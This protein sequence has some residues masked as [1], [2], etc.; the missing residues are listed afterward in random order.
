MDINTTTY[1]KT[2]IISNVYKKRLAKTFKFA[3]N[4]TLVA[5]AYLEL[6]HDKAAI[7][8]AANV[9]QMELASL[10]DNP[11]FNDTT[12]VVGETNFK[13]SAINRTSCILVT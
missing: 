5:C 9:K 11:N 3:S 4:N 10:F 1:A 7:E 12:I 13:A 2:K 6:M 8:A